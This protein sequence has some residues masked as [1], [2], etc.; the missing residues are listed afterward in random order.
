M[1]KWVINE[2]YFDTIV[3]EE[4]NLTQWSIMFEYTVG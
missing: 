2:A 1:G 4:Y 3:P